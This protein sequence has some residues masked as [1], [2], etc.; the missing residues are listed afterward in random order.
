[1]RENVPF[2]SK[3]QSA[4]WVLPSPDTNAS[5]WFLWALDGHVAL[6]VH[7][8]PAETGAIQTPGQ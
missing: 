4:Y 2:V 5:G 7:P 1:M 8:H 3:L 6:W